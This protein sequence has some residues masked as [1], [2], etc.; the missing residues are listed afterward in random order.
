MFIFEVQ[1]VMMETDRVSRSPF[2]LGRARQRVE[3]RGYVWECR[4]MNRSQSACVL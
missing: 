4:G 1:N 2:P 3:G